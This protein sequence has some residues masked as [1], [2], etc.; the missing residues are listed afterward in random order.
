MRYWYFI[1]YVSSACSDEPDQ[2]LAGGLQVDK[3]D[4]TPFFVCKNL[5]ELLKTLCY[6]V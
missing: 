3:L 6:P 5:K 4:R 1:A 2:D